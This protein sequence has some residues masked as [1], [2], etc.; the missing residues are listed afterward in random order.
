VTSFFGAIGLD[1]RRAVPSPTGIYLDLLVGLGTVSL[2][3]PPGWRLVFEDN[4][5]A[6]GYDDLTA[7]VTD[8]D[9]PIVRVGGL[10]ALGALRAMTRPVVERVR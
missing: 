10:I 8:P 2:V 3:L 7:T 5:F 6:V 4:L 1:L 9:A